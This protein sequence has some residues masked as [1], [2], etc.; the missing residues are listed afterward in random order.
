MLFLP[1]NDAIEFF[2][3]VFAHPDLLCFW[4]YLQILFKKI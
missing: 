4:R 2:V 3:I 1:L